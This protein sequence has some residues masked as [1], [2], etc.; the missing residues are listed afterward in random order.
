MRQAVTYPG[1]ISING[2]PYSRATAHAQA[3]GITRAIALKLPTADN[4]FG[5]PL[6]NMARCDG[7]QFQLPQR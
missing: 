7:S 6:A 3:R 5:M 2:I 4:A 1:E